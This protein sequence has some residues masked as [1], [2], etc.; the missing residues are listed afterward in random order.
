[1]ADRGPGVSQF[2]VGEAAWRLQVEQMICA[3]LFAA[4][5]REPEIPEKVI[6][7][8]QHNITLLGPFPTSTLS[9]ASVIK[10]PLVDAVAADKNRSL[11]SCSWRFVAR[12]IAQWKAANLI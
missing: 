8:T 12:E 2:G 4:A 7:R 3:I 1:M 11:Y 9:S 10:Q 5:W 6:G